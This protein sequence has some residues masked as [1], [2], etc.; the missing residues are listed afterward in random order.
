LNSAIR[1]QS[2]VDQGPLREEED[3]ILRE[4]EDSLKST[5]RQQN[6]VDQGSLREEEDTILKEEED[7]LESAIHQKSR[8]GLE[9]GGMGW[10]GDIV[11]GDVHTLRTRLGRSLVFFLPI[12][13]VLLFHCRE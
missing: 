13:W 7:S 3:T 6:D 5:I 11:G 1:Q 8:L 10:G 9:G 2:D 12:I 4:E